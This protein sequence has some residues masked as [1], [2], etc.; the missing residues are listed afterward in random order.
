MKEMIWTVLF[1]NKN[2]LTNDTCSPL[3]IVS[4]KLF[5]YKQC[6][7]RLKDTKKESDAALVGLL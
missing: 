3:S 7:C 2:V 6:F 4:K 1:V 5:I